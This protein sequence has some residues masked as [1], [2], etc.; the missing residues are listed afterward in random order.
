MLEKKAEHNVVVVPGVPSG[1][2]AAIR[3]HSPA[4]QMVGAGEGAKISVV[5]LGGERLPD[6]S[7]HLFLEAL[8]MVEAEG[9]DSGD[10]IL[11]CEFTGPRNQVLRG[12]RSRSRKICSIAG[13]E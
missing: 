12:C 13:L 2:F 8:V 5:S 1:T 11:A 7:G 6:E 4:S 10:E 3:L 9:L